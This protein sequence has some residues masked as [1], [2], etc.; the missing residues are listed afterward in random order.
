M[1]DQQVIRTGIIVELRQ[2]YSFVA[3][4]FNLVKRYWGW[5]LVWL[6]YSIANALAVSFIG[7]GVQAVDK[8]NVVADDF[9]SFLV[10]YLVIGTLMWGFM[11]GIFNNLS[12]MIAWERWEGTIEYTF[13]APVRR[14]VQMTGQMIFSVL[15]SLMFTSV[16]GL[17][18]ALFF[19]IDLRQADLPGALV[20]MLVGSLSIVGIGVIGSI[21]PLLYPERG[22]QLI[23][24]IQAALLL[25]SGVYYPVEVLPNWLQTVSQ[26]S[27]ATYVLNGMRYALLPDAGV[28]TPISEAVLPLLLMG[29]ILMPVGVYCFHIAERYAKRTGKLKRNG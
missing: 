4:N 8:D 27:P 13:M 6:C 16:V 1:Q 10:A 18:L 23:H 29:V 19:D 12:E 24:I 25:V 7:L 3:R 28:G 2:T 9:A 5:E 17:A 20:I 15:W 14:I 26:F 21:L 22:A 11:S